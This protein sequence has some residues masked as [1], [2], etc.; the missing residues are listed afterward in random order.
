MNADSAVNAILAVLPMSEDGTGHVADCGWTDEDMTCCCYRL[1]ER[2]ATILAERDA[3]I[4]A[5]TRESVLAEAEQRI[6][7]S[8]TALDVS[9]GDPIRAGLIEGYR[10]S[11][12]HLR[13]EAGR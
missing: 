1:R 6:R 8:I 7:A 11:L 3:R 12:R 10:D 2:L 5:E 9:D 4:A 13:A